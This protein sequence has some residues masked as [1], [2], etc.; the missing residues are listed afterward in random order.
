MSGKVH[1]KLRKEFTSLMA[2]IKPRAM[3]PEYRK[4]KRKKL[5][6]MKHDRHNVQA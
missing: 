2:G 3:K 4:F 6:E 1:K 5:E